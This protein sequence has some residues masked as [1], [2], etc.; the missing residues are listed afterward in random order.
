MRQVDCEGHGKQPWGGE[1]MCSRCGR[2][3]KNMKMAPKTCACGAR[4]LPEVETKRLLPEA[5]MREELCRI[6]EGK[7]PGDELEA[8]FTARICCSDCFKVHYPRLRMA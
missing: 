3:F 6:Y 2:L 8:D 5:G 7:Q 4:L 1:I